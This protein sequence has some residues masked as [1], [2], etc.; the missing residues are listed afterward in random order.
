[1]GTRSTAVYRANGEKETVFASGHTKYYMSALV[2]VGF[3][4]YSTISIHH[5]P[6]LFSLT[7]I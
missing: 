2:V 6:L 7:Y 4:N 5:L 3:A 1:M